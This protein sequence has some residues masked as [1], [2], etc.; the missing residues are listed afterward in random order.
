MQAGFKK[1]GTDEQG[2][3]AMTFG[4]MTMVML[5]LCGMAMD[6]CRA[7]NVRSRVNDAADSAALVAG[8][9]LMEGKLSVGEIQPMAQ[10]YFDANIKGLGTS[11]KIDTPS[12]KVDAVSGAVNVDVN[13]H[14]PMTLTR[15]A[16]F[17]ALDFPVST[18]AVF[19]PKD[20][21][22]GMA[23]DITGSMNAPRRSTEAARS[24]A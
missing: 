21:E 2:A 12:I 10:K 19:K 16:G 13:A 3:V 9:A 7:M 11:A 4:L 24:S 20:I 8:R 22:L 6:Y 17:K 1:F 14:V 15:L 23:L 18:A 5:F